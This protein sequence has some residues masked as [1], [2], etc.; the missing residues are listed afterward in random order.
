M[1]QELPLASFLWRKGMAN[2]KKQKTSDSFRTG[3]LDT[4]F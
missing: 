3:G 2:Y 1:R 4:K